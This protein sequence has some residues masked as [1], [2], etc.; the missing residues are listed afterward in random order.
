MA[1]PDYYGRN[2]KTDNQIDLFGK[3]ILSQKHLFSAN[4]TFDREYGRH[5][6]FSDSTLSAN[7]V[8]SRDD[9]SYSD[10]S[11]IFNNV[12]LL[13][14][15]K[16]LNTDVNKLGYEADF[17]MADMGGKGDFNQF[18]TNFDAN[19][20]YGFPMFRKYK[21]VACL[22]F[23]WRHYRQK[24]DDGATAMAPDLANR[25]LTTLN[26]FVDFLFKDFKIHTGLA[27]GFNHYDD[28]NETKHNLFPDLSVSKPFVANRISL[29]AGFK[30]GYISND[31]NSLR[32]ANPYAV[33]CAIENYGTH[34]TVHDDLYAYLRINFSKKLML[35]VTMDNHFYKQ[36][37]FFNVD[38][39]GGGNFMYAYY[40]DVNNLVLGADFSF[41]ND[42]MIAIDLGADYYLYYNAPDNVPLLYSPDFVAHLDTKVNYKDKWFFNFQT[43]FLTRMDAQYMMS[44]VANVVTKTLPARFGV[45]M[46]VEYAHSRAVSFFAKFDNITC[47]QYYIWANYPAERFNAMLG[48]TYTIPN[49]IGRN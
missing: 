5:Y 26:P 33:I 31:W 13:L 41:V 10:Y 20:H 36:R 18:S 37:Q 39:T 25:G 11:F 42:E 34:V 43:L 2:R 21:A 24:N 19:I 12:A 28:V 16:S 46:D 27:F 17:G 35:N 6:G 14:G 30:G 49:N 29:T 7:G 47:Q 44:G 32:L 9:I 38:A 45:S 1:S 48:L 40:V 8:L 23:D 4:L 15:A 3:Y 22:H